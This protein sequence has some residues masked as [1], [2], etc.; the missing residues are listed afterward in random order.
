MVNIQNS[1]DIKMYNWYRNYQYNR[2]GVT[3]DILISYAMASM[4]RNLFNTL[5]LSLQT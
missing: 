4:D 2:K 3:S 1:F 5:F